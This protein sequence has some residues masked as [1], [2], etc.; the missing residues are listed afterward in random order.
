M[1]I[2]YLIIGIL[3]S[4]LSALPLGASNIAVINITLKENAKQAF[5]IAI[6]AGIAE[7]LLSY[8]AL[9]CN[10]TIRGFFDR[11]V[12]LQTTIVV[13]LFIIGSYLFFKKQTESKPK[14]LK[15][16]QS[17]YMMGFVLGVLNPPVLIF[18]IIAFGVLNNSD[19]MLSLQSSFSILFLFFLGV[20]LG[21][22]L[23]LYGYSKLSIIIKNRISNISLIINKVTGILLIFI[24]LIQSINLY[25]L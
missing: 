20:Y 5:K 25:V 21:K 1:I 11:N 9:D 16:T 14:K 12:W 22:L 4:I 23:T 6:T 10:E 15:I 3:T 18:W 13:L 19:F 7:V 17:K 8:Y 24:A 2:L